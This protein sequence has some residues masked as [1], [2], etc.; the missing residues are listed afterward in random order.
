MTDEREMRDEPLS[1]GVQR[2]REALLVELVQAQ[3]DRRRRR[4]SRRALL[5]FA[6]LAAVAWAVTDGLLRDASSDHASRERTVVRAPEQPNR[7]SEIEI[8][9]T[10]ARPLDVEYLTE[11][12]LLE[13]L[14]AEGFNLGLAKSE[15]KT[16]IVGR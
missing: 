3:R 10:P 13:T 2:A 5:S 8:V 7:R 11:A 1:E 9:T 15:G 16:L 14:V 6:L 4:R 12:E